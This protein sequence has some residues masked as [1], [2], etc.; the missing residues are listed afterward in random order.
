MKLATSRNVSD[1]G[2]IEPPERREGMQLPLAHVTFPVKHVNLPSHG[3]ATAVRRN[4]FPG[5]E[6]SATNFGIEM[7]S[8][9]SL[10]QVLLL[11]PRYLSYQCKIR[12]FVWGLGT[13]LLGGNVC[14]PNTVAM[15]DGQIHRIFYMN[16]REVA[17][18]SIG[19][20]QANNALKLETSCT[21]LMSVPPTVHYR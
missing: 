7:P 16:I 21:K 5:K 15:G 14:T 1:Q 17:S 9:R 20:Q 2:R 8:K 6:L 11:V 12:F 4:F 10:A 13:R 19:T 18:W 3:T